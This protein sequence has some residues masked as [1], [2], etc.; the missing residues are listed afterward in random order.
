MFGLMSGNAATFFLSIHAFCC[1]I[2][3]A[4]KMI[5]WK[6]KPRMH[7]FLYQICTFGIH[8]IACHFVY[9]VYQKNIP[10]AISLPLPQ[11]RGHWWLHQPRRA[12]SDGRR[13][14][15]R[16]AFT[17]CSFGLGGGGDGVALLL[18]LGKR[19]Q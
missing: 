7:E 16:A 11:S 4:H 19:Q 5:L 8:S 9:C 14:T 10:L 17:F 2:S 1:S 18:L 6:N 15:F 12:P 3:R 13:F